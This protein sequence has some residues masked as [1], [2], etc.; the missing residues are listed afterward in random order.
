YDLKANQLMRNQFNSSVPS[1]TFGYPNL[2]HP[3]DH[4]NITPFEAIYADPQTYEHIKMQESIDNDELD[5]TYLVY[6]RSFIMDEIQHDDVCLQNQTIGKNHIQNIPSYKYKAQYRAYTT[7]TIGNLVTPKTDPGD[8]IIEATGDITTHAGSSI[9]LKPGFH[10]QQGANFKAAIGIDN[11][12]R[13][14]TAEFSNSNDGNSEYKALN[15]L[16]LSV[17]DKPVEENALD[18][19][20]ELKLYPN[21]SSGIVYYIVDEELLGK[22]YTIFTLAGTLIETGSFSDLRG[23]IKTNLSK[24]VYYFQL[25][26]EKYSEIKKII[27]L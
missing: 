13:P 26:N 2:G 17:N 8:Y 22:D 25:K 15:A 11:C 4:F 3:T 5:D 19:P 1:N 23:T 6:C 16:A 7:I 21:P 18:T 10:A 27:I 12:S 24:G 9:S 14:R 20:P